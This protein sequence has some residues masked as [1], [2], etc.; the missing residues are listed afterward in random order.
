NLDA[1]DK[2]FILDI[3]SGCIEH[4]KLLDVVINVFY[5]QNGK[6]LLKADR[7][8]FATCSSLMTLDFKKMHKT[9]NLPIRLNITAILREGALY[10]R[11]V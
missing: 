10:N 4:K 5:A 2:K 11:Q 6:C 3:I 1:L 8:Q 7:N 9:N